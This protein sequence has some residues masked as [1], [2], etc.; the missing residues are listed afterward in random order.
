MANTDFYQRLT[1][2]YIIE[3]CTNNNQLDWL[4]EI[5]SSSVVRKVYPK[6]IDANGLEREDKTKEPTEIEEPIS[7]IEI[8]LAF[9]RK[10]FPDEAPKQT[11]PAKKLS[12][13][14]KVKAAKTKSNGAA[15]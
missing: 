2:D 15:E 4:E 12:F 7:F 13:L 3:W 1:G 11:N 9:V 6:Y 8:K 10:F 14:E 5:S